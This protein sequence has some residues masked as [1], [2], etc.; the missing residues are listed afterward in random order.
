MEH[1]IKL[2]CCNKVVLRRKENLW[3]HMR[4]F[5]P[6]EDFEIKGE[7][8]RWQIANRLWNPEFSQFQRISLDLW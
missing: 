8:T 6:Y 5:F 3:N 4:V 1:V 7:R 2:Y